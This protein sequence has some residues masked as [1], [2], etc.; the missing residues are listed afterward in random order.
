MQAALHQVEL[1]ECE[2]VQ[3]RVHLVARPCQVE[4]VE[5]GVEGDDQER[6]VAVGKTTDQHIEKAI[7][8]R[9]AAAT[10]GAEISSKVLEHRVAE[11]LL[12]H[13]LSASKEVLEHARVSAK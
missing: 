12:I 3:V 7:K 10:S 13:G 4:K 1:R 6:N 11:S 9:I 5:E 8:S 2:V